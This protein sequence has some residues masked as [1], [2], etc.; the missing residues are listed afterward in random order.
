MPVRDR[1]SERPP[2]WHAATV[3]AVCRQLRS[4]ARGLTGGEAARRLAADGPNSLPDHAARTRLAILFDQLGNLPSGLL[5]GSSAL[6]GLVGDFFDAGAILSAVGLNA[7]IGYTIDRGSEDLLASWRRLE[8]GDTQVVR[9]GVLRRV[10]SNALVIGDVMLC[11][12]GDTVPADARVLDAHRLSCDES[13]LTGESEPQDKSAEPTPTATPLAQRSSML[14]AG[15]RVVGGHGRA[16]VVATAAA[17]EAAT[18][19]R[20]LEH[21]AAPRTPLQRQLDQLGRTLAAGGLGAGALTAIAGMLHGRPP[22]RAL[23]SAISLA[24][25]AIP[26]GLPMIATAALVRSMQRLRTRGMVVRRLASAETLGGVTVVCA[27][28]TGT[29]TCN[30]MRLA[31]LE[32]GGESIDPATVRAQPSRLF[33]HRPTLALAAAALNSDV[34]VQRRGRTTAIAG[35][36]TERALVQAAEAAGLDRAALRAAYPRRLLHERDGG[37]HYV[38]SVH[39]VAGGGSLAFIKGA[40]EQVVGLCTHDHG[41]APLSAAMRRAVLARNDTLAAQGLRVLALGWRRLR[42]GAV[43]ARRRDQRRGRASSGGYR[44]IGL[45]G[46]HDPLRAGAA[47]TVREA[48]R[49][50]VRTVILT[51]DQT[52]TAQAVARAVGLQGATV[53]GRAVARLLVRDGAAARARLHRVAAF[54]RVT[55]AD[56]VAI[57][58]ALRAQ[59]EIV[60]MAGDGINDAPA[61]KVADV[62]IAIGADASDLAR[63]AADVVLESEDL[64]SILTAISEGRIVQ[65]NLRRAV[66]YL[67]A[68]NAAEVALA[69]GGALLGLRDPFT[70]L[71]LLWI[72]LL[73]DTLPALA[74]ALEPARSEVLDRAPAPPHAPL[75]DATARRQI[76]REG[77]AMAALGAAAAFGGRPLVFSVFCGAELGYA[78]TCRERGTPPDARFLLLVGGGAALHLAAITLP[79][80]R[81][82]LGLPGFLTARELA[83]FATGL[84]LPALLAGPAHDELIVRRGRMTAAGSDALAKRPRNIPNRAAII[85]RGARMRRA[86]PA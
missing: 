38:V 58:R 45:A 83:G 13:A 7:G 36:S 68:T 4:G 20:L 61:L 59:G 12:A 76:G 51:G 78:F 39:D 60:A 3:G 9:D 2:P 63:H 81:A 6:S 33:A 30:D 43:P 77:F 22:L 10:R 55:P 65:D 66:R 74:L 29:L 62:G 17:T 42:R 31:V 34:D 71:Q 1:T 35:S 50:G 67:L 57:V 54:A 18:V 84:V 26:E 16:V 46:L 47:Q 44:F 72:N 49:A 73:S 8:A 5:L 14:Y 80:L 82:A 37:I 79:P 40:P 75:L 15:T 69:G 21:E 32:L 70:P 24:V 53:D 19:R 56:K 48:A 23:R 11:R 52:R 25:A 27:D 28:K 64:R 41:G 85:D 86:E